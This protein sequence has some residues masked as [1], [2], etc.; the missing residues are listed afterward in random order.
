MQLYKEINKESGKEQANNLTSVSAWL[1][2]EG[3]TGDG[4]P[5]DSLTSTKTSVSAAK[6]ALEQVQKGAHSG[7]SYEGIPTI[8]N[9]LQNR[10]DSATSILN[11]GNI[12]NTKQIVGRRV[13][14]TLYGTLD[15]NSEMYKQIVEEYENGSEGNQ[16]PLSF[17]SKVWNAVAGD[18]G[19]QSKAS[20]AMSKVAGTKMQVVDT[21]KSEKDNP[22]E[23]D[24]K[25]IGLSAAK[26]AALSS[27]K[28]KLL[29]DYAPSDPAKLS[30]FKS[31]VESLTDFSW[32]SLT[33]V[34]ANSG[35]AEDLEDAAALPG[36]IA[37][38]ATTVASTFGSEGIN[39]HS[40][41]A[42]G[43]AVSE[44]FKEF[45]ES[46]K[47]IKHFVTGEDLFGPDDGNVGDIENLRARIIGLP[48][49]LLDPIDPM[50]RAYNNNVIATQHVMTIVPGIFDYTGIAW[51]T[52]RGFST[53]ALEEEMNA[54]VNG[55]S[56]TV[57]FDGLSAV[58][59]LLDSL[60][61]HNKRLANFSPRVGAFLRIYNTIMGRLVS[62]L[63]P[64]ST[65]AVLYSGWGGENQEQ[66]DKRLI[67]T[68]WGGVE[69]AIN[70]NTTVSETASNQWGQGTTE[71]MMQAWESTY[72]KLKEGVTGILGSGF[73]DAFVKN[74]SFTNFPK[75][76]DGSSFNKS[77][78]LSFRLECPYGNT[79][80]LLEYVYKPF[81]VLLALSLP[82]FET[83]NSFTS[84]FIV[85]VDCPGF[86]SI[87]AGAITSL[88][89]RRGVDE[90]SWSAQ[91]MATSLEITMTIMDMYEAMA[92]PVGPASFL[93]NYPMQAYIDNI[94]GMN[95]KEIYTGGSISSQIRT[96]AAYLRAL[97]DVYKQSIMAK[98]SEKAWKLPGSL[99]GSGRNR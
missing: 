33:S 4:A 73:T 75:H 87:D 88:D 31:S 43:K 21:S 82:V 42:A 81:A 15:S 20:A 3:S 66:F 40:L 35:P 84:P 17:W 18:G 98:A 54:F 55:T 10:A 7:N 36:K 16:A 77:Y 67:T 58:R 92:A 70:S 76:W 38:L 60:D 90:N 83:E 80:H 19:T 79:D 57:V 62:R 94:A 9:R 52:K 34:M 46:F 85:R 5:A 64:T 25:L 63:S 12:T 32:D 72:N 45:K 51:A 14:Q 23:H 91:G 50:A 26:D 1:I 86:F 59:Q 68:G 89:I 2:G 95:Y 74:K 53:T 56:Q 47:W 44:S 6:T 65:T 30:A 11:V 39:P 96:Y 24:L 37:S 49:A 61:S 69:F 97:P 27:F 22:A 99:W 71:G 78:T 28:K 48:P 29:D 93:V 41:F 13:A 8:R